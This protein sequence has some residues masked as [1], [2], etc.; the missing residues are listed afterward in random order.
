MDNSSVPQMSIEH[1]LDFNPRTKPQEYKDDRTQSCGELE[2]Q[3]VIQV[4]HRRW[5]GRWRAS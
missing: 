3:T 2:A 4:E 1:L 5:L